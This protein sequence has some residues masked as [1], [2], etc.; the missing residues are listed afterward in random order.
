MD[1][2]GQDY[3]DLEEFELKDGCG[4]VKEYDYSRKIFFFNCRLI[5]EGEYLN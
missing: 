1:G 2:K 4:K 3:D 5:F